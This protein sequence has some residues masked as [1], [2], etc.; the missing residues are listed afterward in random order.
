MI[1]TKPQCAMV[2]FF[3]VQLW[4]GVDQAARGSRLGK[5]VPG[6]DAA[7]DGGAYERSPGARRFHTDSRHDAYLPKS[8]NLQDHRSASTP[9]PRGRFDQLHGT[10][11]QLVFG[12][13]RSIP[14][15]MMKS[16][17]WIMSWVNAPSSP[18]PGGFHRCPACVPERCGEL[19]GRTGKPRRVGSVGHP[20]KLPGAATTPLPSLPT[21]PVG[22]VIFNTLG[23]RGG[24][25]ERLE[26]VDRL[27]RGVPSR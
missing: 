20:V 13:F 14:R 16:G 26:P 9:S 15:G 6:R 2:R 25:A 3:P 23:G 11:D 18:V 12:N 7:A 1:T 24:L 21:T 19:G 8:R 22:M 27:G 17:P 4:R 10:I 5:A